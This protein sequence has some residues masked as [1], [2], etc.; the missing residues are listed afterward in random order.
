MV[1]QSSP[2]YRSAMIHPTGHLLDSWL[3]D[4]VASRVSS[5]VISSLRDEGF[6]LAQWRVLDCLVR[7]G[8]TPM[9]E[10]ASVVLL[11]NPTL[12]RLVDKLVSLALAYRATD[13]VDRRRVLVHISSRGEA[14]Y[15]RLGPLVLQAEADALGM[16]TPEQADNFHALLSH[17]D[18]SCSETRGG[19]TSLQARWRRSSPADCPTGSTTPTA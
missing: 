19:A 13:A 1:E 18:E 16:L 9:S 14:V 3:L 8:D 12:T 7:Q 10:I 11:P 6:T 5:Q 15:R 4:R 17:L 2:E